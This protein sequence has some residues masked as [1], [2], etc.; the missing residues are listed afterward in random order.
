M[1]RHSIWLMVLSFW[2]LS[3]YAGTISV[4]LGAAD[5]FGLLG[6]TIS[7][8]GTSV[9]TGNVGATTKITGFGP[10]TGTATGTVYPF[11]SDPTVETAYTAFENA[12]TQA[13]SYAS[14]A[15]SFAGLTT[16]QTFIGNTA[17]LSTGDISTKTGINLTF[18]AQNNPNEVFVI[19]I[20]GALTVNGAMTFTL[21]DGAQTSNIFWAVKDAATISVG[22]SGPITFDGNIL[23]G[24][25]FTMSAATGGSGTLA[26]TIN[27]CVYAETAN[28]LAGTTDVKGP[29]ASTGGGGV[30]EPGTATLLGMGLLLSLIVYGRQSRKRALARRL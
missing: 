5:S 22:S 18:D 3:A 11:P 13:W 21:E 8:T 25:S 1:K 10:G 23:A 7:N 9:V 26:G 28:T 19:L 15:A 24:T 16:S 29:C 4:N 6:G 30:P 17:Y 27:G 2:A 12:D 20:N 14:T